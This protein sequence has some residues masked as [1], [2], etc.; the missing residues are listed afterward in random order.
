MTKARDASALELLVCLFFSFHFILL[1]YLL[2][3]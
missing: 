3:F 2:F 1:Y